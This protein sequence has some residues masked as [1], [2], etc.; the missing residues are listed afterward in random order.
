M[1][2]RVIST[3]AHTFRC[4]LYTLSTLE[5]LACER[6]ARSDPEARHLVVI[7]N[8]PVVKVVHD[9]DRRQLRQLLVLVE[10][11][12]TLPQLRQLLVVHLSTLPQLRQLLVVQETHGSSTNSTIS[13]AQ[14]QDGT[15][16]N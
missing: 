15:T 8:Y 6:S 4:C 12:S 10:H 2:P 7:V 13:C 11:L 16:D 1:L 5:S 14:S 3:A 9:R